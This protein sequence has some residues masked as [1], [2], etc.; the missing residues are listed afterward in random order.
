MI[1]QDLCT[2]LHLIQL[3]L[4]IL[5]FVSVFFVG[6]LTLLVAILSCIVL[7]GVVIELILTDKM[8]G[9]TNGDIR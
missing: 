4:A 5:G 2:V 3:G 1:K 8:G 9:V 7:Q 6:W